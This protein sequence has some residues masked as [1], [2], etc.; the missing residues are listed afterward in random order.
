MVD[1]TEVV[2]LLGHWLEFDGNMPHCVSASS[3]W[4][5]RNYLRWNLRSEYHKNTMLVNNLTFNLVWGGFEVGFG[6]SV[7]NHADP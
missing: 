1:R 4:G 6:I 3:T 2:D 5:T 7:K